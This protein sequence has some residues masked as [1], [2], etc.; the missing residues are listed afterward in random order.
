[1]DAPAFGVGRGTP[2]IQ[3]GVGDHLNN[4]SSTKQPVG[5]DTGLLAIAADDNSGYYAHN[6]FSLIGPPSCAGDPIAPPPPGTGPAATVIGTPTTSTSPSPSRAGCKVSPASVKVRSLSRRLAAV[7]H[8]AAVRVRV[9]V[10]CALRLKLSAALDGPHGAI[11]GRASVRMKRGQTRIVSVKL[12]SS[13]RRLL[14]H[15][16]KARLRIIART[17]A[18]KGVSPRHVWTLSVP[19]RA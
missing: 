15:R 11:V 8:N 16:R 13:G 3:L 14:R 19:L 6:S 1:M 2:F 5:A 7:D 12:T 4:I 9:R 17:L 10:T 18:V